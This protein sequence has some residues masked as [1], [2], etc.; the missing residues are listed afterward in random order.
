MKKIFVCLCLLSGLSACF[1]GY[2]VPCDCSEYG[3]TTCNKGICECSP[4]FIP[5]R[6]GCIEYGQ[7]DYIIS[8]LNCN[9][10]N[11]KDTLIFTINKSGINSYFIN[12]RHSSPLRQGL[13]FSGDVGSAISTDSGDSINVNVNHPYLLDFF[14]CPEIGPKR[15]YSTGTFKFVGK[16]SVRTKIYF[17]EMGSVPVL[18]SCE[19]YLKR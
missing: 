17:H 11:S 6:S 7:N 13:I 2:Q 1:D 19:F 15:Y 18:D 8:N 14:D 10:F 3:K 4:G 5:F 9:C 12:V 16:D